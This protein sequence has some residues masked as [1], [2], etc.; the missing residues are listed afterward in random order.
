MGRALKRFA[1]SEGGATAVEFALVLPVFIMLLIG[2][3]STAH[4]M[5]AAN[6]LHFAVEEAAR[7][8]AV[9][10]T[11]CPTEAATV[12][13]AQSR[14]SGPSP[15]PDFAASSEGC[16]RRVTAE[17]DYTLHLGIAALTVPLSAEACYPSPNGA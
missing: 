10:Q 4:L 13:F 17:G 9:N 11:S 2:T 16:G 3:V 7:C 8:S 12:A 15:A 6:S 5:F 1:R 14:Y